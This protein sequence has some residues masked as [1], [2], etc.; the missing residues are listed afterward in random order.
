MVAFNNIVSLHQ[1]CRL[2]E[3]HPLHYF[4]CN[5]TECKPVRSYQNMDK[6]KRLDNLKDHN[7]QLSGQD[8]NKS[9][10]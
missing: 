9:L 2:S 6:N 10:V 5:Q 7:K 1:V 3:L 8:M 4:E